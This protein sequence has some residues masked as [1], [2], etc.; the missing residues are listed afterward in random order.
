MSSPA[1][2]VRSL[3]DRPR[4]A[5]SL[6]LRGRL[7]VMFAVGAIVLAAAVALSAVSFVRLVE[8]RRVALD[9]VDPASLLAQEL[10]TAYLNQETGVRGFVLSHDTSFLQ[11]YDEGVADVK[12]L[13]QQL[14]GLIGRDRALAPLLAVAE[15]RGV[16]WSSQFGV[17]AISATEHGD[18]SFASGAELLRSKSLFDSFRDA[19]TK[20]TVALAGARG[21]A[22]ARLGTTTNTLVGVLV[23][24]ALLIILAGLVGWRLL[25]TWVTEPLGSLSSDSRQVT[26]GALY[27][28]VAIVGPPDLARLAADTEAMRRRVVGDLEVVA[29]ARAELAARNA[30]LARSNLELEQFAYVASHDLQEPLRKVISFCQLLQQRYQ[31]QLDDRADQYI[32]F[33]VD[34]ARRMQVLIQDLLAFSRIGRTSEGFVAVDLDECVDAALSRLAW[35]IDETAARIHVGELPE[36]TG[37]PGLLTTVFQNLVGNSLKF[38]SEATP[39]ISIE[40]ERDG[41]MW[42]CSVSDNG[43]GI[44]ARFADRIFVIFQRL[45]SHEAYDGS[46]I[47]LAQCKK[48]VEFHGGRIFLDTEYRTGTR[49]SF[50]LPTRQGV[51]A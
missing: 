34:G 49:I 13:R 19:L 46:G 44:E 37:D 17:P 51:R 29:S 39:D 11:P 24:G 2:A 32:E 40:A 16:A 31:G 5:A 21:S 1:P 38:R 50:T 14:S 41:D 42:Q 15:T 18:D 25:R 22:S 43:I 3:S 9:E 23:V 33:A 28:A 36:V 45:H 47:G 30:E 26:A 7:G 6:T 12:T 35:A 4:W 27:H 10:L 48:I 8:A 20:L